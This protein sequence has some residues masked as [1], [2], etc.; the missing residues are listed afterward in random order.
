M[1]PQPPKPAVGATTLNPYK[2]RQSPFYSHV[3][4]SNGPVNIVTTA[5][6]IGARPDG[7][8]PSDKTEGVKQ[9]LANLRRCLEA[10]GARVEDVMKLTYYI[11]D[12]DHKNPI[13]RPAL[14]DFLGNHRP[15]TTLVPVPAL[16]LPEFKFEIE[17]TAAIPQNP[18]ER[19]D[20]V[21]VGAGLSGLQTA[22]DLHKAGLSVKVLEARDRVGGKTWSQP[23]QGSFCDVGA[24]WINDTNQSRMY[25]L[26][27]RFKLDL[28][29]QNTKGKIIVDDGIGKLKTHPYGQLLSEADDKEAIDDVIR[30]RDLFESTCQK[31]DIS[32]AVASGKNLRKD[33]DSITFEQWVRSLGPFREDALNALKVGTRA[34]LGVEPSDMSALYFLD[35]CKSGGGYMLMR[36]DTKHGGQYL[37]IAQGTQSFSRGLASEL[38]SDAVSFMSPVRRIEQRD[39]M[40]KVTSAR[41]IYEAARVVV[42][43]PTPLYQ[44][45]T[46]DPP[47]P[48]EKLEMSGST[49]LG[50]YCKS[51]VFYRTPWWREYDL[52]GLT[53]SCHGPYSV[54]RDSSVDAD[55]HYS[56][57]C[58]VVGQPAR[59]WMQLPRE[60]RDRAVVEQIQ[61]LFGPFAKVEEPIEIV[62][63]IWKVSSS[64]RLQLQGNCG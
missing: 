64:I 57:T 1:A 32:S 40:V 38:P 15:V 9:A 52:C 8:V 5:G 56:L 19:V 41:G 34:M 7:T 28:V 45:I 26:A 55:G 46:F 43:V 13:H 42:S 6:Q 20:V 62:E 53:Q 35:Y 18:T 48:A 39:G 30:I 44:E 25:A 16:A 22:V 3:S 54:T 17:A 10:A 27:Q 58:F 12:F 33:L 59:D 23:A 29:T 31:I 51:I 47:L 11:V 63:Q 36:S 49:L 4:F 14:L 61:K 37:R 24:A 21:V 60:G 50:D 2:I